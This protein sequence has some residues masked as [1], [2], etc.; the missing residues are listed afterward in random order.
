MAICCVRSAIARVPQVPQVPRVRGCRGCRECA[1][2][3]RCRR[4]S[5][6][7]P[8]L[9]K[10]TFHEAESPGSRCINCHM[11]DVNWR[12]LIRRRDHTYKPPVPEMTA[13][14]GVPNACTTC[15]DDRSPEWA[16]AQMDTWWG[17]AARR[18]AVVAVADTMY[19]AGSGD[20]S[21]APELARLSVDRSQNAFI[22]ASA[23]DFLA[24]FM[25]AARGGPPD[26][27]AV[28]SQTSF[29]YGTAAAPRRDKAPLEVTPALLNSMIGAASD[30]EAIVRA[31]AVRGLGSASDQPNLLSPLSA[32]LVDVSRVVRA[33]TAEVLLAFGISQLPGVAGAALNR[34]QDDYAESLRTFP[35]VAANHAALAWLEAQRGRLREAVE[36]A[37]NALAV[38][39]RLAR[40][41]V[42]KGVVHARAGNYADAIA[43]W[44]KAQALEPS[45]PNI[46]KL[47]EEAERLKGK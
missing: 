35:D 16:A 31:A 13:A 22:R 42:I 43:D 32:R 20:T 17:N 23:A 9:A 4:R 38:D 47:I 7:G 19:R 3:V 37:D 45:Y 41:W 29:G 10:H 34:A 30:P 15:H 18:K 2:R 14:F 21:T 11:S 8:A 46:G 12:L 25:L 44:K 28:Q 5:Y 6:S 27:A 36:A 40:A 26:P 39:P 33:R 24:E 1:A